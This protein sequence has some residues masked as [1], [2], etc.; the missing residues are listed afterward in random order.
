ML[1]LQRPEDPLDALPRLPQDVTFDTLSTVPSENVK[2]PSTRTL[3]TPKI[4]RSIFS[5][6]A[7]VSVS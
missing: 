1:C 3:L 2:L 7:A 6:K 5:S 4:E